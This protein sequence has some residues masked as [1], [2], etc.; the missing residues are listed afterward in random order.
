MPVAGGD[1]TTTKGPQSHYPGCRLSPPPAYGQRSSGTDIARRLG[2][3]AG[4]GIATRAR[5]RVRV[6]VLL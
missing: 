3:A 1:A 6:R 4:T 5:L 2:R